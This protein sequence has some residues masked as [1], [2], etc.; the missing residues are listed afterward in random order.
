M[1]PTGMTSAAHHLETVW[2]EVARERTGPRLVSGAG[3][4]PPP[5]CCRHR[6][7]ENSSEDNLQLARGQLSSR[8]GLIPT[9]QSR[10]AGGGQHGEIHAVLFI[11]FFQ[12]HTF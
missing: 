4:G 6:A 12:A 8:F 7:H 11:L 1:Q 3:Q 2:Q 5:A 9:S 10:L